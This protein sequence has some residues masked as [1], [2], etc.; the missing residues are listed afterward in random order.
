M[1]NTMIMH[2]KTLIALTF[3]VIIAAIAIYLE[4]Q[5]PEAKQPT[6]VAVVADLNETATQSSPQSTAYEIDGVTYVL[7][8]GT[9][10]VRATPD[11]ASVNT[12]TVFGE[13][14]MG[15]LDNDGDTDAA[16]LLSLTTGGSGTFYYAALA[17]NTSYGYRSTNVLF[18]GDRIAPQTVEIH[19]GRAVFNYA[20]RAA[21]EPMTASPSIGKSLWVHLDP[22]K[23][24]IGEFVKNFEGEVDTGRL[25]LTTKPWT[26]VRT[27]FTNAPAFTSAHADSFVLT[28]AEGDS[29][30]AKT[31]CNGVGGT[32]T[33][34]GNSIVFT[35]MM[36]T[37]MYCDGSDES[38]FTQSLTNVSSYSFGTKGELMLKSKTGDTTM[39]FQ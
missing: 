33:Q 25:S 24:E 4:E 37:L 26:W 16:V 2:Y 19:D 32:Y 11:A 27:D 39:I 8:N 38:V 15:D 7:G 34:T 17:L 29:F 36:S 30:S 1:C 13:P 18:L 5:N 9:A 22:K 31:D 23:S 3:M 20:V 6:S 35:N 12:L 10:T 21:N 14:I 28:F